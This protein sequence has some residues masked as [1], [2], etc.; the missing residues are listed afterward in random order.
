MYSYLSGTI[1]ICTATETGD[2][3]DYSAPWIACK[4]PTEPVEPFVDC[5]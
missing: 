5:L 2:I 1:F 4:Q 3:T